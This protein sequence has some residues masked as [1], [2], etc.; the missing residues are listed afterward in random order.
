[1]PADRHAEPLRRHEYWP[2]RVFRLRVHRRVTSM[3]DFDD[4]I[5]AA[6]IAR[7]MGF[8]AADG[9]IYEGHEID[10]NGYGAVSILDN[11]RH[12]GLKPAEF[13]WVSSP[14][15]PEWPKDPPGGFAPGGGLHCDADAEAGRSGATASTPPSRGVGVGHG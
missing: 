1:M 6:V 10:L 12:F 15:W 14:P 8:A 11:V 9:R 2:G 13:E 5:V 4:P 3:D 7:E